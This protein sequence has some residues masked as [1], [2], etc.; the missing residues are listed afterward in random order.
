MLCVFLR[1]AATSRLEHIKPKFDG[2]WLLL[3]IVPAVG[4]GRQT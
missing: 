4:H 1:L 2:L 3:I